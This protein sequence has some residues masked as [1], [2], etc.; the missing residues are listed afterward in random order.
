MDLADVS[1]RQART[2]A[3]MEAHLKSCDERAARTEANS[4]ETKT[5]IRDLVQKVEGMGQRIHKRIDEE[6]DDA[7]AALRIV[8][9]KSDAGLAAGSERVHDLRY[10]IY[11]GA[12]TALGALVAAMWNLVQ[13]R[14]G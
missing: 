5:M 7:H 13:S 1:Q 3:I 14:P 2:D 12:L 11:G 9:E 4:Q 6:R 10:W 8:S